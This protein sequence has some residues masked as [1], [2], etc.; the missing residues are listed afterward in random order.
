MSS[1]LRRKNSR[2]SLVISAIAGITLLLLAITVFAVA[3]EARAVSVQAQNAVETVETL[4]VTSL[5][6][7]ELS[8]ANRLRQSQAN[9]DDGVLAGTLENATVALEA[10]RESF[11]ENTPSE[12]SDSFTAF[13]TAA[14]QQIAVLAD[15]DPEDASII[16][17]EVAT[18]ETFSQVSDA[19]RV[20]QANAIERLQRGNDRMNLI[21]TIATFVVAFIVPSAALYIF[22]ALRRTPR[23]T[24][25]LELEHDKLVAESQALANGVSKEAEM[26]RSRM[27]GRSVDRIDY[28]A[29][30]SARRLSHVAAAHG[31]A[32][33]VHPKKLLLKDVIGRAVRFSRAGEIS[34]DVDPEAVALADEDALT[35]VVAELLRN[36]LTHGST[37]V[38]VGVTTS[39]EAVEISISD[40]GNGLGTVLSEAAIY[41]ND[42]ELRTNLLSG[43]YGF[44][45]IAVRRALGAVGGELRYQHVDGVTT[46]TAVLPGHQANVDALAA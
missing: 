34:I 20:E 42:F 22:E 11:D 28:P 19:L 29:L 23:N 33:S 18:G 2:R 12:I 1:D 30:H 7:A 8:I 24:R 39:A 25:K 41:E 27:V 5:A 10:V 40:E 35:M 21:G 32:M 4:R 6:R 31:G 9:V 14:S 45:L 15:P 13:E 3:T 38:S 44:G 17:A 37:P 46:F 26:L 36:A 16:A 43:D